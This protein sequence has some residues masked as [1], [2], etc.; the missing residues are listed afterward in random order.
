MVLAV[1]DKTYGFNHEL[2]CGQ[3][4]DRRQIVG[5]CFCEIPVSANT[6]RERTHE[7]NETIFRLGEVW[8]TFHPADSDEVGQGQGGGRGR[9]GD[10]DFTPNSRTLNNSPVGGPLKHLA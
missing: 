9:G 4:E 2:G 3:T 1:V 8:T 7:R 5:K 10:L 6:A